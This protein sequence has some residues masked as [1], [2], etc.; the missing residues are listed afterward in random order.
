ME[1]MAHNS[2]LYHKM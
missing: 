1:T 2:L